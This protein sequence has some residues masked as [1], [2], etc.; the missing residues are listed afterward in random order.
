MMSQMF[1]VYS[2]YKNYTDEFLRVSSQYHV[3]W[4]WHRMSESPVD[5]GYGAY[6]NGLTPRVTNR[7]SSMWEYVIPT[8]LIQPGEYAASTEDTQVDDSTKTEE[9]AAN[10]IMNPKTGVTSNLLL[11]LLLIALTAGVIYLIKQIDKFKN[12]I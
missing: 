4:I 1:N 6:V 12:K 8:M 3:S 2:G 7:R 10:K 9:K 11:C 5:N